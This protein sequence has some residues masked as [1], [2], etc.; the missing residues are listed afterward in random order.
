MRE[1]SGESNWSKLS[2]MREIWKNGSQVSIEKE[3][4]GMRENYEKKDYK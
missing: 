3:L 4:Y 2:G 1:K